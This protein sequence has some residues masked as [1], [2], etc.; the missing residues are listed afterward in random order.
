[1]VEYFNMLN[2]SEFLEYRSYK[3]YTVICSLYLVS[4]ISDCHDN[5]ST[6]IYSC[7]TSYYQGNISSFQLLFQNYCKKIKKCILLLHIVMSLVGSN[8]RIHKC[9]YTN[10][11]VENCVKRVNSFHRG[12]T[13]FHFQ[14]VFYCSG[15]N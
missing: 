10:L 12:N 1:M 5:S 11:K 6:V 2:V 7:S 14:V 8:L 9:V 15:K 13:I 3:N 4:L